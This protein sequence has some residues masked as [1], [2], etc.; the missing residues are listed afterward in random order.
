VGTWELSEAT[1]DLPKCTRVLLVGRQ[2]RQALTDACLVRRLA[3]TRNAGVQSKSCQK[4]YRE[5]D[6]E[7]PSRPASLQYLDVNHRSASSAGPPKTMSAFSARLHHPCW[8]VNAC[9]P[10]F[11]FAVTA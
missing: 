9:R 11:R 8:H 7:T 4:R 3:S 1:S 10:E 5:D 2:R 6:K